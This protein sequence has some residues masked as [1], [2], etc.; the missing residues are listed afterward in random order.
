MLHDRNNVIL[1]HHILGNG[2]NHLRRNLVGI[3]IQCL[4][5]VL[6]RQHLQQLV[7]IY[8]SQC[9]Q[10]LNDVLRSFAFGHLLPAFGNLFIRHHSVFQEQF[11][12]KIV[13]LRHQ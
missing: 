3:Q 7:R 4:H 1:V 9:F 2:F 6:L 13:V 5:A 12:N 11:Q 10:S 8:V